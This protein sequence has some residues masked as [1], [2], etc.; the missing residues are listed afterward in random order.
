MCTGNN[1]EYIAPS[2]LQLHNR[3]AK[4]KRQMRVKVRI[5][6]LRRINENIKEQTKLEME[7][8]NLKL[9][10]ENMRILKENERLK[11]TAKLLHQENLDLLTQLEKKKVKL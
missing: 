5:Q 8:S 7:I 10:M 6:R 11:N 1:K 3:K 9:Y 4:P 2:S